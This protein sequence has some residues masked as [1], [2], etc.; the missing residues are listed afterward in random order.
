MENV[1][2]MS[3]WHSYPSV[4]ALGHRMI[5]DLFLDDVLLEEK[6]DGS[7]FSFGVFVLDGMPE[8]RCRSKGCQLN[9]ELPEKMFQEAVNTAKELF[10]V[11]K[12]GWT[13]RAEYLQKPKHNSLAYERTPNK[14][15]IVFDINTGEEEYMS[16]E[17]KAAECN[18][19][20]LECVP[21]IYEGKIDSPQVILDYLNNISILGGQKIEGVVIKNYKRFGQD[22]KALMGKY[23]SEAFKE[24]HS[25]EW[26]NSNPTGGDI[27]QQIIMQYKTPARWNKAIQHLKEKGLLE[28][29]LRDIGLLLKE[30]QEDISKECSEEI[31][32]KLWAWA[33]SH[34][35]RG[36]VA[37]LPEWYKEELLKQQFSE[38]K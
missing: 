6:V 28:G 11:L 2:N 29:N 5:K 10:P 17:D 26:R 27:I 30:C 35:L 18:R 9:V 24:V 38:E 37:G 19:I 33:K 7:Q 31:Q 32:A 8:L 1:I 21:K 4:F 20:G 25:A 36:C 15:L 22:K 34:I 14:H 3:S 23:V 16:Y 12:T 13:Y